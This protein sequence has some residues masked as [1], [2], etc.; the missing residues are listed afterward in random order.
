MQDFDWTKFTQRNVVNAP[1][2]KVDAAWTNCHELEKWF[3]SQAR[4]KKSEDVC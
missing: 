4:V 1:M 2:E 3:L